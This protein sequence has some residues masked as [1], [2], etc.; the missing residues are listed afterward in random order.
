MKYIYTFILSLAVAFILSVSF[1][2]SSEK[3]CLPKD[4]MMDRVLNQFEEKPMSFA[5]NSENQLTTVFANTD[6]GT[7]RVVSHVEN[8]LVCEVV[9]GDT[10]VPLDYNSGDGA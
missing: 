8:G 4:E 9:I 10:Y 2:H 6:T 1:A 7:W 3:V 5:Y